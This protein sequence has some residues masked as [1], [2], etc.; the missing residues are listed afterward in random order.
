VKKQTKFGRSGIVIDN[1]Y[2]VLFFTAHK[3]VNMFHVSSFLSTNQQTKIGLLTDVFPL[4]PQ[5]QYSFLSS[6]TKM[7]LQSEWTQRKRYNSFAPVRTEIPA[8]FY[9]HGGEY[10]ADIYSALEN[11]KRTIFIAGFI[12]L[13]LFPLLFLFS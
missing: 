13:L 7:S 2:R 1:G 8:R 4:C 3:K 9:I 11:A 6:L 10:F 12:F 5:H